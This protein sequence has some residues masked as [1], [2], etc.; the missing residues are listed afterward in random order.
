MKINAEAA[1]FT[2]IALRT[3]QIYAAPAGQLEMLS[4]LFHF[5]GDDLHAAVRYAGIVLPG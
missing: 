3:M 5:G 4:G 1:H 2:G